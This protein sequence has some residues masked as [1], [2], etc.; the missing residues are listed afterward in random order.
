M[1]FIVTTAGHAYTCQGLV[2]WPFHDGTE[3]PVI[4]SGNYTGLFFQPSV[5]RATYIFADI[6][7]LYPWERRLA[8]EMFRSMVAAGLRC[9]NDPARVL[10][11]YPLLRRLSREGINP[12]NIYRADDAPQPHRFPVFI[13]HASGH[14]DPGEGLIATQPE[15]DA[16]LAREVDRGSSLEDCVVIEWLDLR[17]E[18]GLYAKHGSFRVGGGLHYDHVNFSEQ[19]VAKQ[20]IGSEHLWTEEMYA[21]DRLTVLANE[22]PEAVRRA[23]DIAGI[24]WG[25]ADWGRRADGSTVVFEI[26]SNPHIAARKPELGSFFEET[27]VICKR[28]MARLLLEID[29]PPGPPVH[30]EPGEQIGAYRRKPPADGSL[31]RR[32]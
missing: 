28:R 30:I 2:K 20:H 7:R 4:K 21:E 6:D 13:R 26:N 22:T 27:R 14:E 15:L 32:P 8:A 16:A 5:P 1:I 18:R 25:R 12:F 17:S 23:F 3:V 29:S 9:L 19:W 11:R 24:E 31:P 10:T